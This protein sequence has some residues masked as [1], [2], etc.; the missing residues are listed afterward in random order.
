E[1]R[2]RGAGGRLPWIYN[3]GL[4]VSYL[5]SFNDMDLKAKFAVYNIF[6]QQRELQVNDRYETTLGFPNPAYLQGTSFQSPRYAQL[7]VTVDFS[8]CSSAAR[9][10]G[11]PFP[12][13]CTIPRLST[14][15]G[16]SL[17]VLSTAVLLALLCACGGDSFAR[18]DA[19]FNKAF[20]DA[21]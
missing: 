9:I 11:P 8:S 7:Q 13:R 10:R 16:V 5:K 4:S 2:P 19:G 14:S 12:G 21:V 6:D 20:D 18:S 1:L 15:A 17:K 3:L